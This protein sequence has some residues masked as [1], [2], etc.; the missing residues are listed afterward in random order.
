[1]CIYIYIYVC[2]CVCV[3]ALHRYVD[4]ETYT[5]YIKKCVVMDVPS[6]YAP[7]LNALTVFFLFSFFGGLFRNAP[8]FFLT[9]L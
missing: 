8:T 9:K 4:I 3:H 7:A 6:V 2:V 5:Q 1:M